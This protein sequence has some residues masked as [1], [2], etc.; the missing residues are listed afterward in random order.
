M[1][2]DGVEQEEHAASK[3]GQPST[4]KTNENDKRSTKLPI[5]AH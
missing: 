2:K 1:A 5:V 4:S 3:R